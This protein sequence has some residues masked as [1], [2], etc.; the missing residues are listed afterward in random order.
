[1]KINP[2]HIKKW[3][4]KRTGLVFVCVSSLPLTA[5]VAT[6]AASTG[7]RCGD[8]VVLVMENRV[9]FIWTW[10][11]LSKLGVVVALINTSLRGDKLLH[12]IK[13]ANSKCVLSAATLIRRTL[14]ADETLAV[15]VSDVLHSLPGCTL[16]QYGRSEAPVAPLLDAVLPLPTAVLTSSQLRVLRKGFLLPY[17]T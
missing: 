13:E 1:M 9:E 15:Y 8:C 3:M 16:W 7:L 12:C 10:L 11:G 17:V 6:W 5:Q 4:S 2:S 14:I